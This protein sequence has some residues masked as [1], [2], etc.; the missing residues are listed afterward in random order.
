MSPSPSPKARVRAL[1]AL[2]ADELVVGGVGAL[3]VL[4][5]AVLFVA[6]P[7]YAVFPAVTFVAAAAY[8]WVRNQGLT[9]RA[10]AFL[11]T[12]FTVV[13]LGLITVY[14]L[15]KSVTVFRIMGA[16]AFGL[17]PPYWEPSNRVFVLTPMMWGTFV[18]TLIATC[19]AGPLGIAGAIFIAEMAPPR[20]RDAVKPAVEMLAGVPSIVYGFIGFNIVNP[21][22]SDYLG[23]ANL[24]SLFAVGLVIGVMALPTVVSVAEDAVTSVPDSM[25]DGSLALGTTD[26]QSIKSVVAPASFSGLSAAVI[27]GV[28]RA[29]GETMAATVMLGHNQVLPEPVYNVFGNTETLTTLIASQYGNAV[30]SDPYMSALFGAG[31][32][33]FVTVMC[34]SLGSRYVEARMQS[35]LGGAT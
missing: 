26:W 24:G 23:L 22:M 19:V 31:V 2:A 16:G 29:I 9:A 10:L 15:A 11:A 25:K 3:A 5:F 30:T 32:V 34:L 7:G 21:A 12:V 18:T 20:A 4:A 28:G 6:R 35:K 8:G 17:S 14:L 27:L 1:S 33:L 13:I